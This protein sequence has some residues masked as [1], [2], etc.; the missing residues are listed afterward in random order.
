LWLAAIVM[1]RSLGLLS[2]AEPSCTIFM[3]IVLAT[4]REMIWCAPYY[5]TMQSL[6]LHICCKRK[7][8]GKV[9]EILVGLQNG[10]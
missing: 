2:V 4:Y 6:L 9:Y 1:T 7:G 3:S 8:I 5:S 10:L